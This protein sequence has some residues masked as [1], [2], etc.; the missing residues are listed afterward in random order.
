MR[1][2]KFRV[3]N[4]ETSKITY[5]NEL[6]WFPHCLLGNNGVIQD[7]QLGLALTNHNLGR[8]VL[9]QFTGLHDKNKCDIYEGDIVRMTIEK[10]DFTGVSMGVITILPSLG[11]RIKYAIITDENDDSYKT[12]GYSRIA[13]YRT[14]I[15]GNIHQNPELLQP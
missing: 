14:V 4:P 8:I 3:W 9:E 1:T 12:S 15:I 7:I 13:Q 2:I 10:Y 6:G 11:V 5:P